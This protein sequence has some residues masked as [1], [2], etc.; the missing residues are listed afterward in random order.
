[1][2]KALLLA[3]MLCG[4]LQAWAYQWT[5]SEGVTWSF[6]LR[7]SD[8]TITGSSFSEGDMVIPSIVYSNGTAYTVTSIGDYAFVTYDDF[9]Q[10]TPEYTSV[11]IP[12]CIRKIGVLAFGESAVPKVIVQ[13]IAAWCD[14]DFSDD[15]F[16]NPLNGARLF[17][18][19]NT[20]ITDLIIPEGVTRI[21]DFAFLGCISLK[22]VSFPSTLKSIGG[23]AFENCSNITNINIPE[24]VTTIGDCAF[25]YMLALE[26]VTIPSSVVSIGEWAFSDN[27]KLKEV[28]SYITEPFSIDSNTFISQETQCIEV[29]ALYV[30]LGCVNA[31]RNTAGWNQFPYIYEI[32]TNGQDGIWKFITNGSNATITGCTQPEGNLVVPSTVTKDG[33]EFNVTG[34][35]AHAFEE[36]TGLSGVAISEGVAT[37]GEWAFSSC[38]NLASVTIPSTI[39]SIGASAFW[40][41]SGLTKVIVPDIAAWCNIVFDFD[42]DMNLYHRDFVESHEPNDHAFFAS[43]LYYSH[44]LYS[45]ENTEIT[46]LV[47]PDGVTV[48]D[49]GTF[50]GCLSIT[51]VTIPESVSSIA[52]FS[53]ACCSNLAMVS[54]PSG[55]TFMDD[56]AFEYCSSLNAIYSYMVSPIEI[57]ENTFTNY[58]TATLY[59]PVGCVDAYRNT[60]VWNQFINI[61]EMGSTEPVGIDNSQVSVDNHDNSYYTL[62]GRKLGNIPTQ[63]GVYIVN[64]K[65]IVII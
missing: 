48:I 60:D 32:G 36:S 57:W 56:E 16:T 35:G 28:I 13:D 3:F 26:S 8:A 5:D 7:G 24:G 40:Q 18:D 1:M 49:W 9:G 62:D 37:I 38:T 43:P 14:M 47:I 42:T 34:I 58:D 55:L 52:W 31:Y 17:S 63:K 44:R 4:L 19:M 30:P 2:K 51:N 65:K 46:N 10:I 25:S 33:I 6:T 22:S 15:W 39:T 23:D 41:C 45:D 11:T 64:G 12:P 29:D 61:V 53:F 27:I 59:V 21:G 54:L 20:E 50:F